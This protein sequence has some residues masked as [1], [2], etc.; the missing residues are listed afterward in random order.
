M[1]SRQHLKPRTLPALVVLNFM[2][3][4]EVNVAQEELN[5]F[6][7]VTEDLKVKG[8]TQNNQNCGS[9][10]TVTRDIPKAKNR[11]NSEATLKDGRLFW[12]GDS[13]AGAPGYFE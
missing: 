3:H 2:N 13:S 8:L 12:F 10:N 1:D 7:T 6:L 9:D 4:G 5:S 11:L